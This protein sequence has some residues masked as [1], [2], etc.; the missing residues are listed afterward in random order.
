MD[1]N[2]AIP[3]NSFENSDIAKTTE[4][5]DST[6]EIKIPISSGKSGLKAWAIILIILG[7]IIIIGTIIFIVLY[8]FKKGK[9][10]S[11]KKNDI[12]E[13]SGIQNNTNN[14]N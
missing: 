12:T 7:G 3:S 9:K 8:C 6:E 14:S 4:N 5:I 1:K 13:I 11:K 10:E 2:I